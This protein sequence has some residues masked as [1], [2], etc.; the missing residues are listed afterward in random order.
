MRQPLD[1]ETLTRFLPNL[2]FGCLDT[3]EGRLRRLM[4]VLSVTLNRF[5]SNRLLEIRRSRHWL[6]QRYRTH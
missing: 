3:F 2:D 6:G 5:L 4:L 1:F